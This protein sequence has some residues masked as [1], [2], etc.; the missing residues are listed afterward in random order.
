MNASMVD[1]EKQTHG[2]ITWLDVHNPNSET[3]AQLEREYHLHPIHLTESVQK[4]QHTQVEREDD[5]LFLILHFP[6]FQSHSDKIYAGQVGVFLGKNYLI[7][8]HANDSPFIQDLFVSCQSHPEQTEQYFG[9]GAA[10]LL[11]VLV[12]RLLAGIGSIA[13][14]VEAELD[15]T[16]N[17][18]FE[19]STSDAQ[20]IGKIRQKIVRLKR[21]I[22]PKRSLLRDLESQIDSFTGQEMSKYYS[23]NVKAANRLWEGIKEA[24]ETVEIYKDADFTS[25]TERTNRILAL[26]TLVFTFTI[27]VTVMGTLYGMNVF[28]PGGELSGA[29][30]FL[31]RYTTFMVVVIVSL[32]MALGMYLYFRKKKWF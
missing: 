23:N 9:Q 2:D 14:M 32:L 20:R 25:N 13:D 11:Y 28:I 27:P 17:V 1:F 16:E 30:M 6:R 29:W 10:F 15:S 4:V 19:N 7:T 22:G 24:Q 31:G 26:L 5:Y 21:L 8:I 12:S 3:F 18:V